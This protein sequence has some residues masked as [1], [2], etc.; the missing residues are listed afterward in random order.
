[1]F[2]TDDAPRNKGKTT[3][4]T[5]SRKIEGALALYIVLLALSQI[6]IIYNFVQYL[7]INSSD[8]DPLVF[9]SIQSHIVYGRLYLGSLIILNF[10]LF[11][12]IFKKHYQTRLFAIITQSWVIVGG[13]ALATQLSDIAR[14]SGTYSV[15]DTVISVGSFIWLFY[16]IFSKRVRVVFGT[17]PTTKSEAKTWKDVQKAP[18]SEP[19]QSTH[20]SSHVKHKSRK[21]I[22]PVLVVLASLLVLTIGYVGLD[23][24]QYN[25][26]KQ[27]SLF[28]SKDV[29]KQSQSLY[30][31][32]IKVTVSE[33]QNKE[34]SPKRLA[35]DCD[36]ID[37]KDIP[38]ISI[39][40]NHPISNFNA[41]NLC[42]QT[43]ARFAD[44]KNVIVHYFIENMTNRPMSIRDYSFRIDGSEIQESVTPNTQ[45]NDLLARQSR[46][47]NFTLTVPKDSQDFALIVSKK[48]KQKQINLDLPALKL[49][50]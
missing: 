5:F 18:A 44:M 15:N 4:K 8:Y 21:Y 35:S 3:T 13:M 20:V 50:E 42:A 46:Y 27:S 23:Y 11:T 25:N 28:G 1:M 48:G 36:K 37:I 29:Y 41:W 12:L 24:Y 14:L 9:D 6:I 34:I 10:V 19:Q 16:W 38:P 17:K 32:D 39:S 7:L 30:F 22:F 49:A 31:D 33:V 47:S 40:Y 45:I 2:S 26:F 43:A